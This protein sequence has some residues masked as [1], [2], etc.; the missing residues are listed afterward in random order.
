MKTNQLQEQAPLFSQMVSVALGRLK[1]RL[2]NNYLKAYPDSGEIIHLIL[3]EEE[4]KAW[5]ISFFPHVI[6]PDLVDAHI[7]KLGLQPAETRH[8]MA[9]LS[10]DFTATEMPKTAFALCG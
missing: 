8:D 3:D 1:K 10:H 7:A 5:E 4:A 6:M 9:G 2:Q